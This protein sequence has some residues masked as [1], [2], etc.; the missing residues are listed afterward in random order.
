M[1]LLLAWTLGIYA[2]WLHTHYTMMLRKQLYEEIS[3]EH[4]AILELAAAMQREL[5]VE[6]IDPLVLR[7]KQLKE[8]IN[9]EI[10]GGRISYVHL[11]S[12]PELYSMWKAV[13]QWFKA[14][15]WWF[16][17]MLT[18]TIFCST[19]W[20]ICVSHGGYTAMLLWF[21]SF[22][23]WLGQLWAFCIGT[24]VGSRLLIIS[25]WAI[26]GTIIIIGLAGAIAPPPN[27]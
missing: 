23:V 12:K 10:L 22:S 9:M 14:E 3:G 17:A 11:R 16:L 21:W 25:S 15:K 5:D 4:R 24:S 13:R 2:L 27:Y 8:R 7:E 26:M 18:V 6:D 20:I 1:V 19:G